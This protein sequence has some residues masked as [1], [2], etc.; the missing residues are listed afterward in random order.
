MVC[1]VCLSI[2]LE[3]KQ[4]HWN[5]EATNLR[6]LS[7]LVA[8][9]SCR[10]DNLQCHQWRQISPI[11]INDRLLSVKALLR[12]LIEVW[13]QWPAV[14]RRHLWIVPEW[15]DAEVITRWIDDAVR[16]YIV[17]PRL[18]QLI[19]LRTA[20]VYCFAFFLT[21]WHPSHITISFLL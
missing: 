9:V 14:C 5:K 20:Q 6:I 4:R 19:D 21:C 1:A 16:I 12:Y 15:S 8:I 17:E 10:N 18:N 13:W 11:Q 2:F 3:D 7:S